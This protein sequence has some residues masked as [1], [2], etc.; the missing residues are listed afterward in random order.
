VWLQKLSLTPQ[1][2]KTANAV[3][4]RVSNPKE[5]G[6]QKRYIAAIILK[7]LQIWI[8]LPSITCV[9]AWHCHAPT[10]WIFII[11]LIHEFIK[12]N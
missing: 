11:N 12:I 6:L 7:L 4:I 9:G 2:F 5:C 1:A 10:Y 3:F 8:S